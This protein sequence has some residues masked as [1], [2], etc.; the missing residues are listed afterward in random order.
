MKI[1]GIILAVLFLVGSAFVGIT[2]SNK[3]RKS[4]NQISELTDALGSDVSLPDVPSAGRL[5][6]GGIVGLVAGIG[7]LVLL[8]AAFA[9]RSAVPGLAG[10]VLSLSLVAA[11]LYPH[12]ETGP[13]DGMAPG[14]QAFVA[15]VLAVIGAG[16]A[17]LAARKKA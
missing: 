15:L 12:I 17:L 11:L 1:L 4:A 7:S 10:L 9:K 8:V 2:G 13:L 16:G 6:V 5:K 14:P 3:A